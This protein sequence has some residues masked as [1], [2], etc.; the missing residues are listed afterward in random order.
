M[1][2]GVADALQ[3]ITEDG[4]VRADNGEGV[5]TAHAASVDEGAHHVRR[6]TDAFF[7]RECADDD[8]A[9]RLDALF[10]HGDDD[11]DAAEDAEAAVIL[12]CV[13]DRVDMGADHDGGFVFIF[14]RFPDA[15]DVA[16]V[17][18]D[19]LEAGFLH[20]GNDVVA[21]FLFRVGS[22]ETRAAAISADADL[23][24]GVDVIH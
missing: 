13:D 7:V 21:A 19:D 18:D 12:A 10:L 14:F 11:F 5:S 9:L 8:G 16:D 6:I 4:A 15:E 22:C 2:A 23:A 20:E 24:E 17:V 3:F 1:R